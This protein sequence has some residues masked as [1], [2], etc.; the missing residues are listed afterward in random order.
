MAYLPLKWKKG[1]EGEQQQEKQEEQADSWPD[2]A[3]L[4]GCSVVNVYCATKRGRHTERESSRESRMES[5][6]G[7]IGR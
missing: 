7:L 3:A 6:R 1:K 4:A 2:S 5:S